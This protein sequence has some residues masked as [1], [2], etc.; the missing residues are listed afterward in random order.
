M[1]FIL[2]ICPVLDADIYHVSD[3][4]NAWDTISTFIHLIWMFL[5]KDNLLR[6]T[7]WIIYNGAPL[8]K[9]FN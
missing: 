9:I 5:P 2:L 7:D 3:M 6:T 1:K 8:Y 4:I